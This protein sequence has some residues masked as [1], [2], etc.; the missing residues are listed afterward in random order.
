VIEPGEAS[1]IVTTGDE[2]LGERLADLLVRRGV[3]S[4]P[5]RAKSQ[6]TAIIA[7]SRCGFIGI[8]TGTMSWGRIG[9]PSARKAPPSTETVPTIRPPPRTMLCFV[10]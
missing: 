5:R 1:V 7:S 9:P 4:V 6:T 2:L 3:R 10:T 8:V